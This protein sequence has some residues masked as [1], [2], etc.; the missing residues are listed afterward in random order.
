M[1]L[2]VSQEEEELCKTEIH[3]IANELNVIQKV[4]Q[5][6]NISWITLPGHPPK[7]EEFKD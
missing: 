5:Q 7:K 6:Y 3:Q 1:H 2:L 4:N